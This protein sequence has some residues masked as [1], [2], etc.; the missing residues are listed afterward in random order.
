MLAHLGH[1]LLL[2]DPDLAAQA[3]TFGRRGCS[4]RGERAPLGDREEERGDDDDGDQDPRGGQPA[5][6]HW[7]RSDNAMLMLRS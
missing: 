6:P 7:P 4:F 2:L 5:P 3:L 1:D